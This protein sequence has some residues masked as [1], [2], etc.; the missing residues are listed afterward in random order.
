ME[1][2]RSPL[3]ATRR[4]PAEGAAARE[5]AR[6]PRAAR[7]R[8][9]RSVEGVFIREQ[10]SGHPRGEVKR[11]PAAFAGG[12]LLFLV[13]PNPEIL[14][15]Q[16]DARDESEDTRDP[17]RDVQPEKQVEAEDDEEEGEEYFG[18]GGCALCRV[19]GE[20]PGC[21]RHGQ[22]FRP[23]GSSPAMRFLPYRAPT[24]L[25]P[26]PCPRWSRGSP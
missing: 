10:H 1:R 20:G 14:H 4:R 7:R 24:R 5:E 17:D 15:Q 6:V 22:S 9:G 25:T 21:C 19:D 23:G 16:Q 26:S 3:L 13:H 18:H 11:A 12:R 2:V 8:A